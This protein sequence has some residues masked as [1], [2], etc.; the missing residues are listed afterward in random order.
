MPTRPSKHHPAPRR[1]PTDKLYEARRG[2]A[3]SRGYDSRWNKARLGF[4]R[5]HPLCAERERNGRVTAA[6][7][8]DHIVP[9]LGD[10]A[11]FWV[12]ENW[13]PLCKSCHS[14]KTARENRGFGNLARATGS[15]G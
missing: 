15:G 12:R 10:M 4:L 14:A 6:N 13:Q 3:S 9:H 2:T 11:A 1:P 8:V 7:E 5:K